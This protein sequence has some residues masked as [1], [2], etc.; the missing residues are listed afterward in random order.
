MPSEAGVHAQQACTMHAPLVP[1]L[2]IHAPLCLSVHTGWKDSMVAGG[3]TAAGH[4]A[5]RYLKPLVQGPVEMLKSTGKLEAPN[6]K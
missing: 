6:K 3:E 1:V 5:V 2:S 4:V